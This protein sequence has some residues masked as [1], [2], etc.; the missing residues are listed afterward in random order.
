MATSASRLPVILAI[1]GEWE[2]P[3]IKNLS[4][5]SRLALRTAIQRLQDSGISSQLMLIDP[6]GPVGAII[7]VPQTRF[8][9]RSGPEPHEGGQWTK[10][11]RPVT[12]QTNESWTGCGRESSFARRYRGGPRLTSA[13]ARSRPA[14]RAGHRFLKQRRWTSSRRPWRS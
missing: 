5:L 10:R 8:E 7:V 4:F 13:P 6:H 11:G 14:R 9:G 1:V 2:C 12:R 3:T